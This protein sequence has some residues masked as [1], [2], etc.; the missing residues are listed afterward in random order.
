MPNPI[1]LSR[2]PLRGLISGPSN[3]VVDSY[4]QAWAATIH[5]INEVGFEQIEEE[6]H[7]KYV[8][9]HV[10]RDEEHREL[11][12]PLLTLVDVP[13]ISIRSFSIDFS[14]NVAE[15]VVNSS[16]Q[17]LPELGMRAT[18]NEKNK[19][20]EGFQFKVDFGVNSSTMGL[21]K[22][23]EITSNTL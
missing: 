17:D 4:R 1:P 15:R 14:C 12:V 2:I 20:L 10:N 16:R 9:L 3:A 19:E 5:F 18:N 6:A 13:R 11:Q 22:L 21:E 23:K 7:V 8:S